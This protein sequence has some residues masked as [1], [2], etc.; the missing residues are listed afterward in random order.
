LPSKHKT[1]SLKPQYHKKKKEKE[2]EKEKKGKKIIEKEKKKENSPK[3]KKLGRRAQRVLK[4]Y[5]SIVS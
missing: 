4:C 3:C 2:K 5:I 1:L